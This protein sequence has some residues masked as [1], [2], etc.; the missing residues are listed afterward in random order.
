MVCLPCI[1]IPVL[2]WIFHKYIYPVIIRFWNPLANKSLPPPKAPEFT[3]ELLS[4]EEGQYIQKHIKENPVMIFS[5]TSCSYSSVAKKTLNDLHVNYYVDEIDK[6]PNCEKIQQAFLTL[7]G[8]R[9]VPRI[10]IGGKCIGGGSETL[11]LNSQGKLL[12]LL[13]ESGAAFTSKED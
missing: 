4:S 7:T 2:L 12:P 11:A 1:V 13:K 3:D 10:F 6:L 9:T 5:K 8:E